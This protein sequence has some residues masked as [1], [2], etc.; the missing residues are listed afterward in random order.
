[1]TTFT[2]VTPRLPVRDLRQ[3]I[4]FYV[5]RLGFVVELLWPDPHPTFAILQRD[6]MSLGFF[7]PTEHQP[8]PI[9]YAEL[10][11]EVTG[12]LELSQTLGERMTIEWG[13]EVY[14]YGRREFAVR[15]PNGYL[16]IFTEPTT[17]AA[18]TTE[19]A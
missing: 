1:M 4:A 3:T 19:P 13:P 16:V 14:A 7:E 10:Y 18:T 15:D 9:G 8:G 6:A 2:G 12:C 11:V 5:D 17:D